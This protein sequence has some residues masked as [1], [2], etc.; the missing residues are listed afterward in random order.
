MCLIF[1]CARDLTNFFSWPKSRGK[2]RKLRIYQAHAIRRVRACALRGSRSVLIVSPTG[3][4]KTRIAC[5][6]IMQSRHKGKTSLFVCHRSELIAQTIQALG[7]DCN[8]L[9]PWG[10][11]SD[12]PVTIASVQ[13][14]LARNI[15]PKAD[16][17]VFD[18]AHHY[19]SSEWGTLA[20]KLQGAYIL[21]LTATPQ[22]ADG[23]GLGNLFDSLVVVA[24]PRDLIAQGYLVDMDVV[25]VSRSASG[26]LIDPVDAYFSVVK[27]PRKTIVFATNVMHAREL[28]TRWRDKGLK[29]ACVDEDLSWPKR[30]KIIEEFKA[31]KLDLLT[32][33][34]CLTEGFDAPDVEVVVLARGCGSQSAYLQMVGRAMRPYPGKDKALLIDCKGSV[35]QHGLPSEDRVY[36]LDGKAI[37]RKRTRNI[38]Y[39]TSCG[40]LFAAHLRACPRCGVAVKRARAPSELTRKLVSITS[41]QTAAHYLAVLRA[42]QTEKGYQPG[43]VAHKFKARFGHYP[44]GQQWKEISNIKS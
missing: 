35:W 2:L 1:G 21:G 28:A 12:S 31:G 26:T 38:R 7:I 19:V 37:R 36:S 27:Q 33:V 8:V 44:T 41:P 5:E 3:S 6:F 4:G 29:T 14:L 22:R 42:E 32:N 15:I 40:A 25:G 10:N 17:V 9:A 11:A 30:E 23:T 34:Y 43:W 13:T 39:C 18:E 16:L 24:Q 20:Q